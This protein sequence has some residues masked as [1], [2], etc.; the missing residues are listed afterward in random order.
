M[1]T[2]IL[3]WC[4]E[5]RGQDGLWGGGGVRAS[6]SLPPPPPRYLGE[7]RITQALGV[8][9]R[10]GQKREGVEPSSEL[11]PTTPAPAPAARACL[12]D[13]AASCAVNYTPPMGLLGSGALMCGKAS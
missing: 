4:L 13:R 3:K 1:R 7:K 8:G 10:P 11:G 2:S 6:D 5:R 12:R 9:T